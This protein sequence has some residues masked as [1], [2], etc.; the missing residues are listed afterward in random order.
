MSETNANQTMSLSV[1]QVAK[2]VRQLDRH[3]QA[4]L[5][6]LVPE[7][8]EVSIVHEPEVTP[9]SPWTSSDVAE[10]LADF[11]ARMAKL[12]DSRPMRDDDPFIAG[13]T[14]A[15]FFALPEEEQERLWDEAHLEADRELGSNRE[16]SVRPDAL[17]AR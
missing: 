6:R 12:P 3:E 14:V 10:A 16:R 13:L 17:S 7:L 2:L 1:E 4:R 5:L 8:R 9:E 15:E 11:R